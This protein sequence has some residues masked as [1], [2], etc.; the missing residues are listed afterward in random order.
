MKL[1]RPGGLWRHRDFRS[2]WTAETISQFGSQIDDLALGLVAI[3]VLEASAELGV[4]EL[5]LLD[6]GVGLGDR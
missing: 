3:I 1:R 2:L 4:I 6:D 5:Q